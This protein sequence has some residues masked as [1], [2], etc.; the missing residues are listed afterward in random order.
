M[1][2]TKNKFLLDKCSKCLPAAVMHAVSRLRKFITDLLIV[3]SGRSFQIART[4]AFRS[5]RFCSFG[6][7]L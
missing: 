1:V 3:S 2:D 4:T 7:G 5:P 6:F